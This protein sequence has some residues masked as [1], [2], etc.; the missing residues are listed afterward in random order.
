MNWRSNPAGG[1]QRGG[2]DWPRN[3]ALLRGT[4]VGNGAFLQATEIKQRGN[5]D[6]VPVKVPSGSFMPFV[7]ST[8]YR[9]EAADE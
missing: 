5:A 8:S 4:V 1:G 2:S 3:G 7:Y 6:F 9:L